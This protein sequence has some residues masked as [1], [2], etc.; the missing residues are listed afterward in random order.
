MDDEVNT[1]EQTLAQFR[2]VSLYQIPP[3]SGAA[4][5]KSGVQWSPPLPT[6]YQAT[7]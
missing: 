3:R 7:W 1:V 4:G 2:E 5:H 6:V